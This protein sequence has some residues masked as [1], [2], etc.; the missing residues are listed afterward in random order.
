MLVDLKQAGT[1]SAKQACVLAFWAV[2][3][4]ATGMASKLAY[5]PDTKW[6]GHFSRHFDSVAG[7][8]VDS[9][10]WYN[11]PMAQYHRYDA[12]RAFEDMPTLPPHEALAEE[13]K[14]R[15]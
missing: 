9:L 8:K 10:P 15:E 5:K 7:T 6:T 2:R 3:A 14:G 1:L 13:L 4:G 11:V 12:S